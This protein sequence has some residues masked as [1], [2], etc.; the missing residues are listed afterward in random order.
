MK[1]RNKRKKFVHLFTIFSLSLTMVGLFQ[2]CAQTGE[3]SLSTQMSVDEQKMTNTFYVLKNSSELK[4]KP[5]LTNQEATKL[6]VQEISNNTASSSAPENQDVNSMAVNNPPEVYEIILSSAVPFATP[7]GSIESLD[8]LTGEFVYRPTQEFVG[9]DSFNLTKKVKMEVTAETKDAVKSADGKYYLE[10]LKPIPI[11][12]LVHNHETPIASDAGMSVSSAEDEIPSLDPVERDK[13]A[14]KKPTEIDDGKFPEILSKSPKMKWSHSQD[15]ETGINFYEIAVGKKPGDS[16]IVKWTNVGFVN[17]A[18]V[19]GKFT[20]DEIYYT[21][22][23]AVDFAGLR[24]EVAVG[25]G[26]QA[27]QMTNASL[28]AEI[29]GLIYSANPKLEFKIKFS[30][31]V[32][33]FTT[34]NFTIANI[35]APAL[36]TGSGRQFTITA[37]SN[38]NGNADLKIS[39]GAVT[40]ILGNSNASDFTFSIIRPKVPS[41]LTL[42]AVPNNLTSS[43][44]LN[45]SAD[46][47]ASD[48]GWASY[49]VNLYNGSAKVKSVSQ[50]T[51]GNALNDL[52]LMN[53]AVYTLKVQ[54]I[55]V[56]GF[57]GS[58]SSA[59]TWTVAAKA[60]I[61]QVSGVGTNMNISSGTTDPSYSEWTEF[62]FMNTGGIPSSAISVTLS[63]T[64]NFELWSNNKSNPSSSAYEG[65]QG[66][67]L[68]MGA[69]CSVFVRSK[70]S[71]NET[72][73]AS[74]LSLSCNMGC[75]PVI[76]LS[77]SSSGFM[78]K[79]IING[80]TNIEITTNSLKSE[81]WNGKWPVTISNTG[82]INSINPS[83][84]A[85][86]ISVSML[87]GRDLVFN[88]CPSCNIVGSGGKGGGC[89]YT[90][91]GNG[92]PGGTALRIESSKVKIINEGIIAGGGGGGGAGGG[93]ISSPCGGHSSGRGGNYAESGT[94][95]KGGN[96][97][98]GG[99]ASTAYGTLFTV[100][101]A[102]GS[103]G[104]NYYSSS[105][106]NIGIGAICGRRT[107]S[108]GGGG[109]GGG[110]GAWGSPGGNGGASVGCG[111]GT[112]SGGAGGAVLEVTSGGSAEWIT[113][114]SRFG[115]P[116]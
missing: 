102:G 15:N 21:S 41:S 14:P 87:S 31:P 12:V 38:L 69:K 75:P 42:G 35:K 39:K 103:N 32:E 84:S 34:A 36:V 24:S 66:L 86:T 6:M 4:L 105:F 48:K 85:I 19:D 43:P 9:E 71:D 7:H 5:I 91:S 72:F 26:W 37:E 92:G 13:V 116:F 18:S 61:S 81:G 67:V 56:Q 33:K 28:V 80:G 62:Q 111:Q 109:G 29:S 2:N 78:Y 59:A 98:S 23:R 108:A 63:S 83:K 16:D 96:G 95:N 89:S 49:T 30:Q 110:G 47:S 76:A 113:P 97:G 73:V 60:G 107:G 65:C 46:A 114:G 106:S 104:L 99:D 44:T 20:Q 40:D 79:K 50:F 88:N 52:T 51:K 53:G 10:T 27:T 58:E 1:I 8:S 94:F 25:D 93:T 90:T 54:G 17:T 74:N 100:S 77:G 112:N 115:A 70:S 64:T 68:A 45:W 82:N 11:K 22:I 57:V 3:L 55:D 101:Q